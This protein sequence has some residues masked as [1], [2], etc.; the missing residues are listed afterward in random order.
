MIPSNPYSDQDREYS[1]KELIQWFLNSDITKLKAINNG[2]DQ[3]YKLFA[4]SVSNVP[5]YKKFLKESGYKGKHKI[6][7]Q[8]DWVKVPTMDKNNYISKHIL[9]DLLPQSKNSYSSKMISLSSGSSGK[10]F[11]WPRGIWQEIEGALFHEQ[12]LTS[13]FQIDKYKTLVV[14]AFSMGSYLAGTYTYNSLRWVASKN[15][16]MTVITPG[17][18]S[19]DALDMINRLAPMYE[20]IIIAGYPPFIKDMLEQGVEKGIAWAN[21]RIRL[22]LASEFFSEK[23]REG[24]GK[25]AGI[26]DV[27]N[28]ITNIF[29][30]SEGTLFGWETTEAITIRRIAAQNRELH[31]AL[32]GSELTPTLVQ[33]DDRHRFFESIDHKLYLTAKAGIPLIRYDLKDFGGILTAD[34]RHKILSDFGIDLE[35]YI[36]KDQISSLPM[37]Y[38]LGRVDSAASIYGVLIYPEHIK[39]ALEDEWDNLTGKFTMT[40]RA[41]GVN[42]AKLTIHIEMK[43]DKNPSDEL[44]NNVKQNIISTLRLRSK[45]YATLEKVV[46]IKAWPKIVFHSNHTSPY[47]S[48][49][50]KQKWIAQ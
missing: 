23:W 28:G 1:E 35:K 34:K 26:K 3:A 9:S 47:F 22:L 41:I 31:L 7:D 21:W 49:G 4:Q 24:V 42:N 48:A 50:V 6:T 11:Y 30:A 20:Q 14:V 2:R 10:A 43:K 45:E 46:G 19:Q 37:V 36:P 39:S 38:V 8:N 15:Y 13:H 5:A 40:A 32:F 44:I 29:G 33:Y 18:G 16:D 12:L 17:L 25:I 27:V